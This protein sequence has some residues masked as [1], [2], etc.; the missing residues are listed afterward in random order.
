MHMATRESI[1]NNNQYLPVHCRGSEVTVNLY[2][3]TLDGGT[4]I[5]RFVLF[6]VSRWM[7][8]ILLE[9]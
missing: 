7:F 2:A 3:I 5:V 6:P 1:A 8:A 9:K 4:L